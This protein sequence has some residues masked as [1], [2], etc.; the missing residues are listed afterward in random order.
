MRYH[1]QLNK[2]RGVLFY[3]ALVVLATGYVITHIRH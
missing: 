2:V 3:I 1:E